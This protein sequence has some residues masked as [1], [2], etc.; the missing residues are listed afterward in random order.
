MNVSH[1]HK[2]GHRPGN[3]ARDHG[4]DGEIGYTQEFWDDR[5]RSADRLWSKQPNRQLVAQAA[6]LT[7]GEALDAG[8]GEGAD[9]IWLASRGW[10]VT[11]AD[12]SRVALE[13]AVRHAAA[14]GEQIARRITWRHED[15]V[16]WDPGPRRFDLVS[17]QFLHLPPD[18]FEPAYRRLAAAVRPGGTLLAVMHHVDDVHANVGRP[19]GHPELFPSADQLTAPLDPGHWQIVVSSAVERPATDLDG[20]PTTV[21]DTVVRALRRA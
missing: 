6:E 4:A 3:E 19:S 1:D 18:M 15:L 10:T 5:Y 17:L 13:R 2:L 20:K 9:A 21:T 14:Q 7:P 12:L 11:A 16:S 8:S